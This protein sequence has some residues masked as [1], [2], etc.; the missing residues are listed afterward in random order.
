VLAR[1]QEGA[2]SADELARVI[3]LEAG[4]LAA[5]LTEL[6]LVGAVQAEEGV[7]RASR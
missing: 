6:E 1:V 2:A 7:Y 3:G 4:E 5:A